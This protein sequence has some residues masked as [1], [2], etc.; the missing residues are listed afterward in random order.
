MSVTPDM[1]YHMGGVPV[2]METLQPPVARWV[3]YSTSAQPYADLLERN[4][5]ASKLYSTLTLA[6]TAATSGRNEA[7]FL[8][9]ENHAQTAAS[10]STAAVTLSKSNIHYIGMGNGS[11]SYQPVAITDDGTSGTGHY[12][13]M[14]SITGNYNSFRNIR[15]SYG[16]ATN[17]NLNAIRIE[18]NGNVFE[19]CF[20]DGPLSTTLADL[21]TVDLVIVGGVGNI[22]R[23]CVFGTMWKTRGAAN[24]LLQFKRSTGGTA[25][26]HTVF[27]NCIFQSNVDATSVTHIDVNS[28]GGGGYGPQY[29][30]GCT[31]YFRWSDQG[32][33]V[34]QAIEWGTAGLT[35]CLIFDHKCMIYG[36]D[37]VIV[38]TVART[39]IQW[40]HAG[41]T[42]DTATLGIANVTA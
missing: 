32:D 17:T 31:L 21:A 29:F 6:H 25:A 34:T 16:N 22:F 11:C 26:R 15:F 23:N 2:G 19:N 3:Y 42:L 30:K 13:P 28:G 35:A 38:G 40:G 5:D 33:Q 8:T 27:E 14:L 7:I 24:N 9:P 10:S 36:A 20:F 37:D 4:P 41:G 1:L 18:G 12:N 39:G